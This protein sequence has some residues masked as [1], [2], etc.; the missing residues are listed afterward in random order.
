MV[1]LGL[2]L[3]T[4]LL[5]IAAR[6]FAVREGPLR[7]GVMF[8]LPLVLCYTFLE[9]PLRFGLGV[10]VLFLAGVLADG[11][12]NTFGAVDM[13]WYSA[14][15]KQHGCADAAACRQCEHE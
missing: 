14:I 9:R 2:G 5:V 13:T 11:A 7:V 15:L 3:L 1:A 10:A 12:K 4:V 6:T 8:G